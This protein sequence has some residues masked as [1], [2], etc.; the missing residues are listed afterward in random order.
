M[1]FVRGRRAVFRIGGEAL[2]GISAKVE[3][4]FPPTLNRSSLLQFVAIE[5]G[6]K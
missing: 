6:Q 4:L 5:F 1:T 2:S 3:H